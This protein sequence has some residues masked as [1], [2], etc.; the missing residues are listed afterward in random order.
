MAEKSYL[1]NWVRGLVGIAIGAAV[2]YFLFFWIV[3]QGLYPMILPGALMGLGCGVF[4]GIKSTTLGIVCGVWALLFGL[5]IE[6]QFA[7]F[8]ADDSLQ[9]FLGHVHQLKTMTLVMIG[10]GGLIGF[11]WGR[12]R[13]R[14]ERSDA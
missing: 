4:S 7:P 14:E 11:W 3:H 10:L 5:F 12:G 6:W 8:V 9:Y 1:F 13:V 2:G